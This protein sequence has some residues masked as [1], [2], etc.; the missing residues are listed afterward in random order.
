MKRRKNTQAVHNM[1]ILIRTFMMW[2]TRTQKALLMYAVRGDIF[3]WKF[4][5]ANHRNSQSFNMFLVQTPDS[6]GRGPSVFVSVCYLSAEAFYFSLERSV[7]KNKLFSHPDSFYASEYTITN[8][9]IR[10]WWRSYWI[11]HPTST[12]RRF[13]YNKRTNT[14][15]LRSQEISASSSFYIVPGSLAMVCS[16]LPSVSIIEVK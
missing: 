9:S 2:F 7:R 8:I 12:R 11:H 6:P 5:I 10:W 3:L 4:P 1:Y 15:T 16:S 13:P 14:N